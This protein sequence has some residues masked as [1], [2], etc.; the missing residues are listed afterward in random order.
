MTVSDR[1]PACR[2]DGIT[3]YLGD[4]REGL[5]ALPPASVDCC[6]TSPSYWGLRDYDP[7]PQLWGG[8]AECH[9]LWDRPTAGDGEGRFCAAYGAWL[10]DLGLEPSPE[11]YVRHLVEVFRAARRV[12]KPLAT[13]WLPAGASG[14]RGPRPLRR[15]WHNVG[16]APAMRIWE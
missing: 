10:G 4:A 1:L 11:L 6:I 2:G 13:L 3:V 16:V 15:F 5:A 9:H 8:D 12:L 7:V 14:R